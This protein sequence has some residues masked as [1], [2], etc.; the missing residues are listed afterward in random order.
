M[1]STWDQRSLAM[2]RDG[3]FFRVESDDELDARA[4]D[5]F[6]ENG[7]AYTPKADEAIAAVDGGEADAAFLVRA[8]TVEQVAAFAARGETM[9]QKSTYFYPKLLT[10]MVFNSLE[11]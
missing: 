5:R 2:Y 11:D 1:T 10:G 4:V 3:S 9:P 7:V 6:V 8:P